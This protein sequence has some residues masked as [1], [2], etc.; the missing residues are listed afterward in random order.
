M[1]TRVWI[2]VKRRR[3]VMF[4]DEEIEASLA[5]LGAACN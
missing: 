3:R 4:I 1:S 2:T 5:P